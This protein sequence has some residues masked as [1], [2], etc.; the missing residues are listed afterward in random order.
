MNLEIEQR[1][2]EGIPILDLKGQLTLG[3]EDL[4]L[5]RKLTSLLE[6]GKTSVLL[7]LQHVTAMDSAGF[8]TL[9]FYAT[10]LRQSGGLLALLNFSESH[11]KLAQVLE[12][13]TAFKNFHDEQEAVN[14]FFPDRAGHPYDILEFVEEQEHDPGA[15]P[16]K[17]KE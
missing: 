6:A 15:A 13:D 11:M 4:A 12:L 10:K 1:E 3:D 16:A 9:A 8:G 2:R 14:S 7:N 17:K 5:R